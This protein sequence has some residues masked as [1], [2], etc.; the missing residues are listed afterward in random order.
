[1]RN[2]PEDMFFDLMNLKHESPWQ[3]KFDIYETE[4]YIIIKLEAAGLKAE[5][6]ELVLS[7][8]NS[9]LNVKG[10]RNDIDETGEEKIVCH[11]MEVYYGN[12][13]MEIDLPENVFIDRK[14]ISARYID[15][16]LIVKLLKS[17]KNLP[18][19]IKI[20]D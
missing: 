15:G 19:T 2:F 17:E 13:D 9:S 5:N 14:N 20:E 4:K 18:K 16:M 1:M 6:V 10:V 8:D 7:N 3:P 11:Q 12:F